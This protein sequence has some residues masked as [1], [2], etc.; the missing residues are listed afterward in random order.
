MIRVAGDLSKDKHGRVASSF[1]MHIRP[2]RGR[3]GCS[4][5]DSQEVHWVASAKTDSQAPGKQKKVLWGTNKTRLMGGCA[6]GVAKLLWV[7]GQEHTVSVLEGQQESGQHREEL[8][9]TW[10]TRYPHTPTPVTEH[11]TEV[12]KSGNTLYGNQ[13]KKTCLLQYP[14]SILY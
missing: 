6:E 14:S 11:V 7:Q 10:L 13:E 2:Y 3:C 5:L 4:P 1:Q 9:E 12:S 8:L